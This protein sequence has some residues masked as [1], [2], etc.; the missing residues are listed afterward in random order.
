[1]GRADQG[2]GGLGLRRALWV[3]LMALA[4]GLALAATVG[5]ASPGR[6][7]VA[8]GKPIARAEFNHWLLI[9]AK[10]EPGPLIVPADP[11]RF[12]ECIAQAR[13]GIP[14]VR[15]DSTQALRKDC[16]VLFSEQSDQVLDFLI[17]AD[18]QGAESA[19]DGIAITAGQ[20]DRAF[21]AAQQKQFTKPAQFKRFLRRTGQ[22]VAD[23]K[24]RI[25]DNLVF[26]ALR[27][28]ERL[29]GTAL[30]TE[31]THEFKSQTM[32]ARFYVMSDCAGAAP[33]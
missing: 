25:R 2:S 1:M 32:C 26:E 17:R 9:T 31:L 29:S 12:A 28:A 14:S 33:G 7:A 4:A 6:V 15:H 30:E 18:W 13:A 24:A 19:K 21:A 3:A 23:I 11:P 22:T 10:A 8:A 27:K 20:V 5:A 16:G